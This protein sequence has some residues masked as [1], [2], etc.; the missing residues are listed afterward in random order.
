MAAHGIS[1]TVADARFAK[2][3]DGDLVLGLARQHELLITVEEGAIGGFGA[4]VM[5]FLADKGAL[6]QAGFKLRSMVLPDAFID[7]DTPAA[8]YAKAGLDAAGIV[9]KVFEVFGSAHAPQLRPA[10]MAVL[11][12]AQA[13][14]PIGRDRAA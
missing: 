7:H 10:Q 4:H 14:P 6:D 8:M 1:A 13:A 2:P 12:D 9:D 3:L 11:A 5:Q